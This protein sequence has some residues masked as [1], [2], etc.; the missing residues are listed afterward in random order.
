MRQ[1]KYLRCRKLLSLLFV[2]GISINGCGV[3]V[4]PV[5]PQ[6]TPVSAPV[7]RYGRI[8][9]MDDWLVVHLEPLDLDQV[10]AFSGQLWR[11][12]PDGSDA[13]Q[14]QLADHPG[15]DRQGVEAPARLPNGQLGFIVRC[16]PA[17]DSALAK[18]D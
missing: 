8:A 7:G 5:N 2:L 6:I 9:W 18:L 17:K 10:R 15:C 11:F 12:H 14:L 13:E 3:Q 4:E 16:F 1:S